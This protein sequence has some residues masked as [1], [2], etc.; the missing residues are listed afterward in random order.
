MPELTIDK[1]KVSIDA[2]STILQAAAKLGIEIPVM[3]HMDGC[4][5]SG[6]CMVC[7][8]KELGKNRLVPACSAQAQDGMEIDTCC[9]EV[10][11]ARRSAL[12]LLLSDHLGDCLGPCQTACPAGMDI[13]LMLRQIHTGEMRKAIATVKAHIPL[14]GVLGWI[15]PAPCEK[16]CRMSSFNSPVEICRLKRYA[17]EADIESRDMY[18]PQRAASRNK[19]V[20]IVGA[21]PA[22]L[23]AAYYLLA[24]GYDCI[25][26]DK[27]STPGGNLVY[28]DC[29]SQFPR[30]LLE[31]EVSVIERLGMRFKGDTEIGKTVSIDDLKSGNDAVLVAAGDMAAG[32]AGVF[33]L[34]TSKTGIKTDEFMRTGVD[35]VFAAGGA[36]RKRRMAVSS[37]A[38]GHKAALQIDSYLSS[39]KPADISKPFNSRMPKLSEADKAA[40]IETGMVGMSSVEPGKDSLNAEQAVLESGRCLHCDCREKDSCVLKSLS[41][42][43]GAE[44]RKYKSPQRPFAQVKV[45]S[46]VVYEPGKCIKCGRCVETARIE[47]EKLGLAMTGRGFETIPA[48]S[49]GSSFNEALKGSAKKCAKACPTGALSIIDD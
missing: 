29:V 12:E 11:D 36:V 6:G 46:D 1:Q 48:A 19:S 16:I 15:C 30:E 17:A 40:Y 33:G 47:H 32:N 28:S 9:G 7:V 24:L 4:E 23:T 18:L 35:G 22:G 49:L 25:V 13:P 10:L 20:A 38:D 21:G 2:G 44:P 39:G 42:I 27:H 34:E 3:C 14:P 43:Y 5:M 26:Y 45:G 41:E 8:V 37:V 31:K